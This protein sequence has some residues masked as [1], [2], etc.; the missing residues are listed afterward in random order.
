MD[1]HRLLVRGPLVRR[2]LLHLALPA[3]LA[4]PACSTTPTA[5]AMQTDEARV[6]AL[7][8]DERRAAL[9]RDVPALERLWA[10]SFTV[11]APNGRVVAGRERNLDTFVRSGIIDF[12][13]FDRTIEYVRVDGAFAVV[14]G[15]ETV[16]PR[17]DAPS[18]G[19]V[20][21]QEVRRRFTNVWRRDGETW[22]LCWRHANV[23]APR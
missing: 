15:L 23:T 7:D 21:G 6:R 16:V 14:M 18:V 20:A 22:R 13:R 12:S 11:N 3:T 2:A 8:D 19:L 17:A 9:A 10:E 1:R 4:A 5:S